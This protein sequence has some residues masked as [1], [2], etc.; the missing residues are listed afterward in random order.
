LSVDR[1]V[2]GRTVDSI[3]HDTDLREIYTKL[4]NAGPF[5][6]NVADRFGFG[7]IEIEADPSKVGV[8]AAASSIIAEESISI[9]QI[10]A[11]DPEL[12]PAPKL[13][14]IIEKSVP[15]HII[16]DLLE[17]DGVEKVSVS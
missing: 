14:I 17:I 9:R 13:T 10:V 15:G 11:D 4:G 7:L 3:L 2:V 5:F 1:R 16:P 8:V 6:R 12:Y